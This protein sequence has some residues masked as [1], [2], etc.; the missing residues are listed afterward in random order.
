ML[1]HLQMLWIGNYSGKRSAIVRVGSSAAPVAISTEPNLGLSGVVT[2]TSGTMALI[3]ASVLLGVRTHSWWPFN[4][5]HVTLIR[6]YTT[7]LGN[8][9]CNMCKVYAYYWYDIITLNVTSRSCEVL[10]LMA[11]LDRCPSAFTCVC[12]YRGCFITFIIK[13]SI[14]SSHCQK[15]TLYIL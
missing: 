7:H 13:L 6:L 12:V 4:Q 9:A 1:L 14:I 5:G 2:A 3:V 10:S 11:N 8:T 15:V